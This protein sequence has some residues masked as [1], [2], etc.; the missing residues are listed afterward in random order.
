MTVAAQAPLGGESA[1]LLVYRYQ[2]RVR[3]ELLEKA[4]KDA[5]RPVGLRGRI[6]EWYAEWTARSPLGKTFVSTLRLVSEQQLLTTALVLPFAAVVTTMML[7]VWT[8]G[9]ALPV[10]DLVSLSPWPELILL[11]VAVTLGVMQPVRSA[12]PVLTAVTALGLVLSAFYAQPDASLPSL[13]AAGGFV[14]TGMAAHYHGIARRRQQESQR[15]SKR[16]IDKLEPVDHE[17]GVLKWT[18]A[19]LLFDR[20]LARSHRYGQPLS[21]LRVVIVQ[22]DALQTHL[23][24]VRAAKVLAEVGGRL[25][26]SS[27]LVD[28]VAYHGDGVFD[29]LLPDTGSLGAVVVAR[30][31]A[32]HHSEYPGLR[33]RVG[34][35]PLAG[36]AGS[37]DD[38]LHC[39]DI[40]IATAEQ[41]NRPYAV[42]GVAT[43]TSNTPRSKD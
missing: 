40:A 34:V 5:V 4:T 27:R 42:F 15:H 38:L 13:L 35:V 10:V 9:L 36:E 3:T 30:R 41:Y 26:S 2:Q 6:G 12:A 43:N 39:G 19:S 37:I 16:I 23:G 7:L 24:P 14:I 29:L 33:L 32:D 31:T 20:E 28:V 17:A 8:P 18:H 1:G 25:L 22:W 21:L 11:A